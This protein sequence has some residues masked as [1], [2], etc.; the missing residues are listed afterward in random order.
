MATFNVTGIESIIRDLQRMGD[1]AQN[2]AE[3][4]LFAGADV[5]VWH[6]Q[7]QIQAAGHIGETGD[8]I[9][10]VKVDKAVKQKGGVMQITV[11]PR[12][13][14]ETGTR[15]AEKAFIANY[16]RKRQTGSSFVTKAVESGKEQTWSA[17]ESIWDKFIQ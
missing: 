1:E 3:K 13:K 7:N 6:W 12:G 8:M 14:D 17:M 9:R 4:M 16:G 10:S 2:V 15:N 5:M 11:Y